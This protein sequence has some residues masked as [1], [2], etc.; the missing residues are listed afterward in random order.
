MKNSKILF[1]LLAGFIASFY[2]CQDDAITVLPAEYYFVAVNAPSSSL[3]EGDT[4]TFSVYAGAQAGNDV[5][6]TFNISGTNKDGS[7]LV[8]GTDFVV[9]SSNDQPLSTKSL[10]LAKGMGPTEFKVAVIDDATSNPG[11]SFTVSLTG[12]SA[13]YT[14]GMDNGKTGKDL[15]VSIKD[16]EILIEM[17]ELVGDWTVTNEYVYSGGWVKRADYTISVAEVDPTTINITGLI[18]IARTITAT[19]DLAAKVKTIT[20]PLQ[21]VTPTLNASYKTFMHTTGPYFIGSQPANSN[22]IIEKDDVGKISIHWESVYDTG[23]D[24]G[25]GY[26]AWNLAGT[27]S[28]GFFAG[29]AVDEALWN[30][31]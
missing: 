12:N 26:A 7:A 17:S 2:G 6:V 13:N 31:D 15:T 24:G 22:A 8:E 25:Y 30:K 20:I 11:R 10:T 18:G 5:N 4:L 3:P 14:L 9:L 28:L 19:V 27:A 16:D 23:N 29:L 1:L 21:E